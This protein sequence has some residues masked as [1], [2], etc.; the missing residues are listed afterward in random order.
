MIDWE[1]HADLIKEKLQA[2]VADAGT[3]FVSGEVASRKNPV[4]YPSLEVAL[5]SIKP[6]PAGSGLLD[7]RIFWVVLVR[8]KSVFGETGV[9]TVAEAVERSLSGFRLENGFDPL[10]PVG[11][12]PFEKA[13]ESEGW[14]RI[15][16][17][18]TTA[19]QLPSE[20]SNC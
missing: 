4:A 9:V 18:T 10:T 14:A 13:E 1:K 6:S 19:D 3:V 12:D 17:F 15:V 5:G 16:T 7:R 11:N 20:Y 8:S 2:K